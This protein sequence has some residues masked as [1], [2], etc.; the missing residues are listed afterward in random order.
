MSYSV[1]EDRDARDLGVE[2]WA[3]YGVPGMCDYP[4]C[5]NKLSMGRGLGNKCEY[6][7]KGKHG[8]GLYFCGDHLESSCYPKEHKKIQPTPDL[9]EWEHHIFRDSS[10]A[11]WREE[12][13]EK[14]ALMSDRLGSYVCTD[15]CD[16]D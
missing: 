3:G 13:P 6:T 1:Y 9:P 7:R 15:D 2:R 8:C 12:N 16:H 4:G 10:W 5:R 14:V 11:Q